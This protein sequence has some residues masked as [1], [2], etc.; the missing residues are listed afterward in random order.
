[1]YLFGDTY[2]EL[3]IIK[4][5]FQ[6]VFIIFIIS[7]LLIW[8]FTS[9]RNKNSSRD[10]EK[11]DKN[12]CLLLVT[13]V[14]SILF[15]NVTSRRYFLSF[16]APIFLFWI[17]AIS[18]VAGTFLRA[19]SVWTLGR[20]FTLSV[21]VNS[22]Q[23]IIQTGPYK[24]LRHPA[25]SGSILSLIGISLC[26][27]NIIGLIGTL[28]IIAIIYGYRIK[29]EEQMLEKIFNNSYKGYKKRTKKIIPFI[30]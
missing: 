12:S 22:K 8:F 29:V 16:I 7:E 27:R 20:F 17:G 15:L 5:V 23:K 21:Q 25:Y 26:F 24:Y 30:W 18:I 1:M 19:Y 28:V 11:G 13:G 2:F 3:P 4:N 10:K 14:F 6:V 9:F